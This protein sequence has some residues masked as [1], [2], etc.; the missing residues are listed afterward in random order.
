MTFMITYRG[1]DSDPLEEA[2]ELLRRLIGNACRDLSYSY[3]CG[4]YAEI[5]SLSPLA[6]AE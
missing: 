3:D 4:M 1:G 5:V 2:D 6:R